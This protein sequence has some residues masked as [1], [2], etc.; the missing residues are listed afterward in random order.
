MPVSGNCQLPVSGS[1]NRQSPLPVSGNTVGAETGSTIYISGGWTGGG[2]IRGRSSHTSHM[3]HS[4]TRDRDQAR[5]R[6]RVRRR[7]L[8]A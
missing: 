1:E 8:T 5:A 4:V 6:R 2:G 3:D 7:L